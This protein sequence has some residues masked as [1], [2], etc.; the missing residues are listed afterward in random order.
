MSMSLRSLL[1]LTSMGL[2]MPVV[3]MAEEEA[4]DFRW[5]GFGTIGVS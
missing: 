3:I 5:S 4:G 1:L 2:S